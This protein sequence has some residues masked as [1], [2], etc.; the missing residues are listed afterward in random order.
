MIA[1]AHSI[2][3]MRIEG[4]QVPR[5]H[6]RVSGAKNAATRLMAASLL[7]EERISLLNFPTELVDVR[8]KARFLTNIGVDVDLVVEEDRASIDARHIDPERLDGFDYPIRTTY[9]L[10]AGQ[11]HRTGV[12]RIPYPGGCR[13][14]NRKHDL[15]VMVWERLGCTVSELDDHILI[16]T[17]PGGLIG[18]TIEFPITTVGGTENALLCGVVARGV[19]HVRNAYITPEVANLIELLRSMG[20]SIAFRGTSE[21]IMEG[22]PALRGASCHVIPDRIEALTWIV[23][24]VLS[25]GD[26][27]IEDVPFDLMKVPLIHLQESGVE[28]FRGGRSVAVNQSCYPLETVQPFELACGTHPGVISD[29]QPFFVLLALGAAGRSLI[30]DYRYPERLAYLEQLQRFC[31]G[32]IESQAGSAA[33]IRVRGPQ[34]FQAAH[35]RSTDLRGS[36]ALVL[37]ALLADGVSR[38]DE[39]HMALRGYNNLTSKLSTLGIHVA[40]NEDERAA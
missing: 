7:T 9:L 14:G 8:E 19:T 16:R 27:I 24:A 33:V 38:V 29:M 22:A 32:S 1:T 17:P 3:S 6:I 11:L 37:A 40:V 36:M 26:V 12:A 30:V 28:Y 23:F 13:L 2:R 25:R 31:P 4:G 21:I 10:A 15:H 18:G 34:P 39:V 35:V 20:A 5:G